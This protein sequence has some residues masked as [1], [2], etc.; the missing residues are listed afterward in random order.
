MI[1]YLE[2]T[3]RVIGKACLIMVNGVGYQVEVSPTTLEG[4]ALK[5]HVELFIYTHVKE[6]ALELY[7]FFTPEEKSLF[8]ALLAVSGVGPRSAL[9]LTGIG[10]S[11]LIHAIQNAD[12]TIL[13]QVPRVGKKLAQKIIIDLKSKLGS[14]QEL[15]L[16]T[17]SPAKQE[18]VQAL[19]G[20]GFAEEHILRAM[21]DVDA[22]A[23]SLEKAMKQTLQILG[24]RT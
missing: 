15:D 7:G 24:Q 11:Q 10:T 3:P 4:L 9:G 8:E 14:F 22:E 17:P 12:I 21:K 1:G 16:Q 5:N 18:V 20:L 6:D 19:M 2:G 13:T 23:L